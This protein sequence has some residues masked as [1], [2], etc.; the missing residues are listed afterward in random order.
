MPSTKPIRILGL[1]H[2]RRERLAQ[3]FAGSE[4]VAVSFFHELHAQGHSVTLRSCALTKAETAL[5]ALWCA[6]RFRRRDRVFV[7]QNTRAW[8]IKSRRAARH[9]AER[10]D[11]TDIVL[12][13]N[14]LCAPYVDAPP[15]KPYTIFTDYN[16]ALRHNHPYFNAPA[17]WA[18]DE[19][20]ATLLQW[21]RDL[22]HRARHLFV[23]SE[24]LRASMIAD[25][26]V[27]PGRVTAV[28][29]GA[30]IQIPEAAPPRDWTAQRL[31]FIGEPNSFERKG[32]PELLQ[33]FARVRAALPGAT[34]TMVG[35]SPAQ[36]GDQPGV[37]ALGKIHDRGALA[38]LLEES[39]CFVLPTR[40]EPFGLSFIEA[41]AYRLPVVATHVDAVP[42]IVSD[43]ET[44]LLVPPLDPDALA[45]AL[46]QVLSK[47]DR[48]AAMG[49]A[50]Y[51]R[52]R[53]RYT[54]PVVVAQIDAVLAGLTP[55]P[56]AETV[57]QI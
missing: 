49:E 39:T 52:L 37:R 16:F 57:P 10:A 42:E 26:G 1:A 11:V 44:G 21:E 25:Y 14:G 15:R 40:Q 22:Y 50:G 23:V 32:G 29:R 35:P 56:T 46:V 2:A 38:A 24:H 43:S 3:P 7:T 41:M 12:L 5:L 51:A 28:G 34:L 54:W 30:P 8:Q 20:K 31:L 13:D 48:A 19:E 36:V 33:A 6:A 27:P 55:Q 47:P 17:P 18:D 4:A 9:V 45:R 53:E